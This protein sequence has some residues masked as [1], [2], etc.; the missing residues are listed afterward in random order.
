[1]H[2]TQ[3]EEDRGD[4]A[5]LHA[6]LSA[7]LFDSD[8][9]LVVGRGLVVVMAGNKLVVVAVEVSKV[10]QKSGGGVVVQGEER[11]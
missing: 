4:G 2:H 1:M 5:A 6:Q 7:H 9:S 3:F 10:G 11:H 8:G